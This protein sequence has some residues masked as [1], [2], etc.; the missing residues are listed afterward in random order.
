MKLDYFILSGE[1]D[2][3]GFMTMPLEASLQDNQDHRSIS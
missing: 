3:G 1:A 2:S